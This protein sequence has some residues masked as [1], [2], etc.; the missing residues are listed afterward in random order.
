MI[1]DHYG[2]IFKS[3]VYAYRIIGRISFPIYCFLL[4]EGYF[5]TSD[6][7]KYGT[8]LLLFAL[9][10]EL[11]FDF[12]FY[13]KINMFHQNIFFTLFIG[14]AALYFIDDREGKYRMKKS[15]VV[16]LAILA[17]TILFTDYMY[18]GIIYILAFY[19]ARN[20]DKTKRLAITAFAMLVVNL[21]SGSG[22]QH[23]SLLSLFFIYLYDGTLGPKNKF[24]QILFYAAYP[25]HLM[26][27]CIIKYLL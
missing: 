15:H 17:A 22:L 21:V 14:L 18:I 7:K 20:F 3:G 5:H 23:F 27:F 12:A 19:Y 8:R 11:P 25:A 1:I 2:A 9:I 26:L 6:V 10:S 4:V 16:A 13:G 24:M